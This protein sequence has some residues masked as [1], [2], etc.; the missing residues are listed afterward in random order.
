MLAVDTNVV[1]RFLTRDHPVQS[2]R[3]RDLF[4]SADSWVSVTVL[5]ETERVLR[6]VFAYSPERL[7]GAIRL[8][9]GLPRV[10]LDR[11][12]EVERALDLH[13]AG[14]DFADAL[15][16]ALSADC[17]AFVSFDRRRAEIA[18]RFGLAVREP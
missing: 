4:A 12:S 3:A 11:A 14:M 13:A 9:A 7:C 1:I 16:L 18:A 5:L 10:N 2:P 17:E 15:H 8:L 6:S